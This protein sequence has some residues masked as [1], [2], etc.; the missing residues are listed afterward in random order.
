MMRRNRSQRAVRRRRRATWAVCLA[1]GGMLGTALTLSFLFDDMGVRKY[2]AM[3]QQAKHLEED[4]HKLQRLNAELRTDLY[5]T[6][7]DPLRIEELARERL[8]F[9]K[10]GDTVYQVIQEP[11]SHVKP[12]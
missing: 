6:Q 8:G 9:V 3:L 10:K 5:R 7:Y 2:L 12:Q 4:I 1:F 11:P